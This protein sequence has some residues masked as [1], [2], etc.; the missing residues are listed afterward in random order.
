MCKDQ[1]VFW[2]PAA[3]NADPVAGLA[4]ELGGVHADVQVLPPLPVRWGGVWGQDLPP[5]PK[6]PLSHSPGCPRP[7]MAQPGGGRMIITHCD[8]VMDPER[9]RMIIV[10]DT[11]AVRRGGEALPRITPNWGAGTVRGKW[12]ASP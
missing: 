7:L 12:T 4:A 5:H 1:G 9:S 3:N 8:W 10:S 2:Q 6:P 11:H